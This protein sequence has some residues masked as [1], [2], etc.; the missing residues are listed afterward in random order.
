MYS[1]TLA[2]DR[3]IAGKKE[4]V[5][6]LRNTNHWM[7]W[8]LRLAG[9]RCELHWHLFLKHH[10]QYATLGRKGTRLGSNPLV[11]P[12]KGGHIVLDMAMSQFSYGKLQDLN[13]GAIA[14]GRRI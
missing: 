12:R 1:A 2:M 10:R 7:R 13:C 9:G 5:A 11:V 4:W 14:G 6:S 3:A 8:N